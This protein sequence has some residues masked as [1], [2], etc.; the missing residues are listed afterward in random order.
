VTAGDVPGVMRELRFAAER[1]PMA[2]VARIVGWASAQVGFDDLVTASAALAADPGSAQALYEFGY[3]AIEHGASYLAIPA[4]TLALA[5]APG[6]RPVLLELLSALE[7]EARHAEA[8]AVLEQHEPILQA[9]PDRYLLVFNCIMA[10]DIERARVNLP[11]LPAPGDDQWAQAYGRIRSMLDRAAVAGSVTGLDGRDLRGWH[12]VVNGG[13][14]GTLSPYGYDQGMNGRW[15]Y[16]QDSHGRCLHG[17]QRL[18]LVLDAAG[19]R[20][21][22]VSLLPDRSSAILGSAAAQVL[23][24]PAVAFDPAGTDT[25]VVAYALERADPEV[26]LQLRQRRDGQLLFEHATC[27]TDPPA[28]AAD[29]STLLHQTNVAPWDGYTVVRPGDAPGREP[30]DDRPV[31][32]LATV[33]L[34]ADPSP[35]GAD[36]G[37]PPDPDG[38]VVTFVSA[39]ASAWPA[40]APQRERMRSPGPVRSSRFL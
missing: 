14:L 23:G 33:I 19:R 21:A 40:Q 11:R 10:G 39:V 29:V 38:D 5:D 36:D 6:E 12:F 22:T 37:A 28:L 34:H 7:D 31:E 8:I 18:R 4:L 16:L 3:A 15:A 2:E 9:W 25:V 26:V 20:P 17:L 1:A 24:L 13:V 27:W 30:P 35:D 32:E